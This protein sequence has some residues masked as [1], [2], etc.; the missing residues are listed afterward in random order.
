MVPRL[1]TPKVTEAPATQDAQVL[2][3][4][5]LQS[6]I[7]EP[8]IL[9]PSAPQPSTHERAPGVARDGAAGARHFRS[10]NTK[11]VA[12]DVARDL[13]LQEIV[14]QARLTTSATGAFIAAGSRGVSSAR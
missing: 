3:T 11:V 5:E 8:G 10:E 13:V 7:P 12:A 14:Q 9:E 2:P 4:S 6:G 1:T